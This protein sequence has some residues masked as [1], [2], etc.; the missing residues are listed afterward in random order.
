MPN[1]LCDIG[2]ERGSLVTRGGLA[3]SS[4]PA[5]IEANAAKVGG[6]A[7][8]DRHEDV[9]IAGDAMEHEGEWTA[10][11]RDTVQRE[12]PESTINGFESY[13]HG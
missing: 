13:R 4:V 9:S 12:L 8:H 10:T 2:C 1:Q 3:R 6:K 7:L 5:L 11:S